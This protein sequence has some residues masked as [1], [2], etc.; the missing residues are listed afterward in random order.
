MEEEDS[1]QSLKSDVSIPITEEQ[2]TNEEIRV[3][4]QQMIK[5]GYDYPTSTITYV[6]LYV[7]DT[8]PV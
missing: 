1:L 5:G 2:I 8:S 4:A 6:N 3:A 7:S